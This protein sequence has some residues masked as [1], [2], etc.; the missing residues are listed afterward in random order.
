MSIQQWFAFWQR[1]KYREA[2]HHFKLLL[3]AEKWSRERL[4]SYQNVRLEELFA[5]ASRS[6]FYQKQFKQAGVSKLTLETLPKLPILTKATI[7]THRDNLLTGSSRSPGVYRNQT[8]GSTGDPLFFYQDHDYAMTTR[9]ALQYGF[10]LCGYRPADKQMYIWGSDYDSKNHEKPIGKLFDWLTNTKFFNAFEVSEADLDQMIK[11]I[12][13]WQPKFI[14]GYVNAVSLLAQAL[15]KKN[16]LPTSVKGVQTTAEMLTLEHRAIIERVFNAQ[17]FDRYGSREVSLVAHEC[18]QHQG[19]HLVELNNLVEIVDGQGQLAKPGQV[20]RIIVT[21]LHNKIMPFLRYEIGD[22]GSMASQTC[23]CGR[24]SYRLK[25]AIGRKTDIIYSPSGKYIHGEFFTHLFYKIN[26]IKQFQVAQTDRET[27]V[28]KIVKDGDFKYSNIEFLESVIRQ[29]GDPDFKLKF[30][31]PAK[32]P[33]AKSG[34][35]R[36]TYSEV[37]HPLSM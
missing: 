33:T 10:H 28:V 1:E 11:T 12:F 16:Q 17:V 8:G 13:N 15:S 35:F 26:G 30:E 19:L 5:R 4:H 23:R 27:L 34:K 3:A 18:Q 25:S 9:A 21:N 31:F 20:G 22:L 2:Y 37:K 32:I 36:F 6:P 14:W 29:H 24:T 7:Q